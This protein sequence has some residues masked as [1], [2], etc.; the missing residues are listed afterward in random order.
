MKSGNSSTRTVRRSD[1][2]PSTRISAQARRRSAGLKLEALEERT[3]LS[4]LPSNASVTLDL[5]DT[6]TNASAVGSQVAMPPTTVV[7]T[8]T[9]NL[10][11]SLAQSIQ[12]ANTIGTVVVGAAGARELWRH[13]E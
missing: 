3:L 8:N 10:P 5:N 11:S 12:D 7:T 2:K 6:G 13:V 9:P 1:R 4:S